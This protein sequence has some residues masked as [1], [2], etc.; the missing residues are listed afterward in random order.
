MSI[1]TRNLEL[2]PNDH[3]TSWRSIRAQS[4][5]NSSG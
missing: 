3:A 1:R 5:I 4:P 2:I